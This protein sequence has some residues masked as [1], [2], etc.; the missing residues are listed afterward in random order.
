MLTK[1]A[2][3]IILESDR[4][5]EN[6][7]LARIPAMKAPKNTARLPSILLPFIQGNLYL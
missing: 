5:G 2:L 1:I 6:K 4:G 7:I 3:R